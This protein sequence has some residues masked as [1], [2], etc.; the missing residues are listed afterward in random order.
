MEEEAAVEHAAAL[1]TRDLMTCIDASA[2]PLQVA[3][4]CRREERDYADEEPFFI[5]RVDKPACYVPATELVEDYVTGDMV[6]GKY[7]Y[8]ATRYERVSE[9]VGGSKW[10]RHTELVKF[11]S[12]HVICS[13]SA[14][15]DGGRFQ[16]L[17]SGR[18]PEPERL[19]KLKPEV[20]D[21]L[22][23]LCGGVDYFDD[24]RWETRMDRQTPRRERGRTPR[25]RHQTISPSP[26]SPP[27]RNRKM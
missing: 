24:D 7:M 21:H 8:E 2:F 6:R 26:L 1:S 27:S 12:S 4:A 13:G 9:K 25:G 19:Y 17:E 3:T 20:S 14:E 10:R 23:A 11:V 5:F 15:K 22:V 16:L 18:Q